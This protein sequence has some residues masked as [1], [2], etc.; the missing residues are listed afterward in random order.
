MSVSK[1]MQAGAKTQLCLQDE[2]DE[3][4]CKACLESRLD[5]LF[6]PCGHA[7]YCAQC[8]AEWFRRHPAGSV[9]CPAC[10][11]AVHAVYQRV[12][13]DPA[14]GRFVLSSSSAE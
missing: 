11:R 5:I 6:E 3:G 8:A 10:R 4:L 9:T 1:F 7:F 12:A 2:D 14:C 13:F